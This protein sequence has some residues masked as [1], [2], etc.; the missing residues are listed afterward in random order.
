MGCFKK[1]SWGGQSHW[2]RITV[3]SLTDNI[4]CGTAEC[5]GLGTLF[6]LTKDS[7]ANWD[8][9]RMPAP[10]CSTRHTPSLLESSPCAQHGLQDVA[11]SSSETSM[12]PDHITWAVHHGAGSWGS[13]PHTISIHPSPASCPALLPN[14]PLVN[15]Q[16]IWAPC[17]PRELARGKEPTTGVKETP[18]SLAPHGSSG[19]RL[20]ATSIYRGPDTP[21]PGPPGLAQGR[22]ADVSFMFKGVP[23]P[24]AGRGPSKKGSWIT[25]REAAT[26][27]LH[28]PG[29][30]SM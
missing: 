20:E 1:R 7:V 17:K 12:W 26:T 23:L 4:S 25:C 6:L 11:A 21:E 10:L 15:I 16:A 14:P 18:T 2:V 30:V 13:F 19:H 5:R 3:P 27:G 22:G 9:G 24:K 8:S 28:T 29:A